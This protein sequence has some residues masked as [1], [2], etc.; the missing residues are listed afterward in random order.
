MKASD[1]IRHLEQIIKLHGDKEVYVGS[2]GY[3]GRLEGIYY[4]PRG[5]GYVPQGVFKTSGGI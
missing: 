4:V 1:L 3:P 5:D 2:P